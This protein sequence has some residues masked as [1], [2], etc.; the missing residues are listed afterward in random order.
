[1]IYRIIGL[2][3]W[4]K[5]DRDGQRLEDSQKAETSLSIVVIL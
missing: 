4:T 3:G 1:M 5:I 2:P